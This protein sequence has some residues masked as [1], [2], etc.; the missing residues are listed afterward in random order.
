MYFLDGINFAAASAHA[1]GASGTSSTTSVISVL[2]GLLSPQHES[3]GCWNGS[4]C[5]GKASDVPIPAQ[6]I[7]AHRICDENPRREAVPQMYAH[8]TARVRAENIG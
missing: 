8:G 2:R 3:V 1:A 7:A 5:V 4:L 6:R